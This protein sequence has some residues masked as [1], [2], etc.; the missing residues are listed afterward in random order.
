MAQSLKAIKLDGTISIIGFVG[1][2]GES[3]TFLATLQS[4]CIVRG[5]LVGSRVQF[6]D[7]VSVAFCS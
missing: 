7:M 2:S 1:G 3:P 6:E 5:I 4:L